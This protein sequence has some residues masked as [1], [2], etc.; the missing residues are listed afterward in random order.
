M[1]RTMWFES[2]LLLGFERMAELAER[3]AHAGAGGYPPYNVEEIGA[4][5]L[6][7]TIAV[8]GFRADELA[9][10]VDGPHLR[11]RGDRHENGERAFLHQG[12]AAR[13]FERGFVLADGW[14]VA[15]A[16]LAD[17]LLHIDLERRRAASE[18][19]RIAIRAEA[20]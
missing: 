17:G 14:E 2:P 7:I 5:R 1:K 15:G 10:E 19:I 9:V 3:V 8:A 4:D 20:G 6:Q 13:R 16:R 18:P 12:I 11:A